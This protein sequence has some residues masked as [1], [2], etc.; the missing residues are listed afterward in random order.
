[1]SSVQL[2]KSVSHSD[3]P[4]SHKL[5]LLRREPDGRSGASFVALISDRDSTSSDLFAR[6]LKS[7]GVWDARQVRPAELE[8]AIK[9]ISP[10]LVVVAADVDAAKWRACNDGTDSR[11]FPLALVVLLGKVTH[12]A[13]IKAFRSG[14]RGIFCREKPMDE[15]IECAEHVRR[16]FI[17]AGSAETRYLQHALRN[18][19]APHSVRADDWP[20]LTARE[21]QIV[22]CVSRGDTNRMIALELGLS[23]NTIK[24]YLF[25]AF[26]K[27]DVSNRVELLYTLNIYRQ[28]QGNRVEPLYG[29]SAAR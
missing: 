18:T 16:G 2:G 23:E 8:S 20:G 24:S 22:R 15:F 27:L 19:P 11:R 3:T 4:K 7:S 26:E 14:A 6:S 13:V 17:W 28:N 1:M 12:E 5:L 9:T 21:L 25:R 29:R 10:D